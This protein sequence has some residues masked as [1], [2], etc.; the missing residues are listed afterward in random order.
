MIISVALQLLLIALFV[1]S[2]YAFIH[3]QRRVRIIETRSRR[4][5]DDD[6]KGSHGGQHLVNAGNQLIGG[7]DASACPKLLKE[8]GQSL[9]GIGNYWTTNWEVVT[10]EADD[11]AKTLHALSQLM[12]QTNQEQLAKLYGA[13][14]GELR[15]IASIVGCESIGPPSAVP[16]L[17]G[18]SQRLQEMARY[19]EEAC[20][21]SDDEDSSSIEDGTAFGKA[22]RNASASIQALADEY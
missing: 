12:Q 5:D 20:V 9:I 6:D 2:N 22:L 11:A 17:L 7:A 18:L 1:V 3:E 16:N 4:D 10:Y 8:A 15:A 13:S 19:V 21:R 14:S